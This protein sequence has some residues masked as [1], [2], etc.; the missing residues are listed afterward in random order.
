[1]EFSKSTLFRLYWDAHTDYDNSIKQMREIVELQHRPIYKSLGQYV[2]YST[3]F[4]LGDNEQRHSVLGE[5]RLRDLALSAP[6][7]MV[8]KRAAFT[9]QHNRLNVVI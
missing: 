3:M 4:L 9:L 8:R 6:S 2:L 5:N 1:M 7:Q